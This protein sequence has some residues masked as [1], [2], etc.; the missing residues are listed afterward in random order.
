MKVISVRFINASA[1][2][3]H[4]VKKES[5]RTFRNMMPPCRVQRVIPTPPGDIL[6]IR[7]PCAVLQFVRGPEAP[8]VVELRERID[9][10]EPGVGIQDLKGLGS[11]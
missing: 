10:R 4:E 7:I 8:L 11:Q 1:T 3:V 6:T 2:I 5:G 9:V